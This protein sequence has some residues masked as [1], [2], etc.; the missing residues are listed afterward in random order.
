MGVG[1]IAHDGRVYAIGGFNGITRMNNGERY[2]LVTNSWTNISEMYSPR[3]NFG[4]EVSA[5]GRG[6]KKER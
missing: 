6:G 1:V 4:V 2:D 3:S 5:R